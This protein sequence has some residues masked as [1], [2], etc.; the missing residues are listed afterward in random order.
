MLRYLT[1]PLGLD[2]AAPRFQWEIVDNARG[3]LQLSYRISV[4]TD[5]ADGSVWDSG[6][7]SSAQT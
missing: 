7:V 3:V 5:A 2:K 1:N 4:G 6:V